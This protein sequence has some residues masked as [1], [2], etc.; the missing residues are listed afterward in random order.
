M[1]A[2]PIERISTAKAPRRGRLQFWNELASQTFNNLQVDALDPD[3]FT[4]EMVRAS[5]GQLTVMSANSAPACV[6]R[7]NDP[8][9]N[10]AGLKAFDLHFQLSGRSLNRQAGRQADLEEGDFTL[11]DASRPYVVRFTEA[12]HML[13]IKIPVTPLAERLGDLDR[14]ICMPMSGQTGPGAML[15]S[16]LRTLWTQV[17]HP[18]DEDWAETVS[19]VVLDL[20]GLAYRP[21]NERQTAQSAQAQLLDRAKAFIDEHI[22]DPDLSGAVIADALGVSQRY[23]QM[24]F[25]GAGSTPSAYILER[26][27]KLAAERL[28]RAEDKGITQVAMAVGFNDLTHFGRAFRRRYGVAPRSY[29]EGA[30]ATRWESPATDLGSAALADAGLA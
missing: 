7:V 28:R 11:C 15:S 26:R 29:R 18:G 24:L 22:C 20:I 2:I 12:N 8:Y 9:R 27:L 4:G 17:D 3:G 30:R 6:T 23:V 14:L 13:C 16:F 19:D 1:P 10:A 21:L 5:I 25:A